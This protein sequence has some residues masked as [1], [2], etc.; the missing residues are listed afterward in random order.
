M[1]KTYASRSSAHR[2]A[3]AICKKVLNAPHYQATEGPDYGIHP[4]SPTTDEMI[5]G[6][7][8]DRY[9]VELR[10]PAAARPLTATQVKSMFTAMDAA[11]K[12]EFA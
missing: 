10:G 4:V 9:R 8:R 7:Y 1:T 11:A 12:K 3:R 5:A 6:Q 2:A